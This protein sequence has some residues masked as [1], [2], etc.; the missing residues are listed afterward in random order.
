MFNTVHASVSLTANQCLLLNT[1]ESSTNSPEG[2]LLPFY[3]MLDSSLCET[4][5][6]D[7]ALLTEV[8]VLMGCFQLE[9]EINEWFKHR[10]GATRG[11]T[12]GF[13]WVCRPTC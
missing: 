5:L 2:N 13:L 1:F 7:S 12:A 8:C 4:V 6:C 11:H 9:D 10:S 3:I